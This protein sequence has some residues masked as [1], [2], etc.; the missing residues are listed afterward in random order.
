MQVDLR[1]GSA[2]G[3]NVGLVSSF[4][5]PSEHGMKL[6]TQQGPN[7][8]KRKFLELYRLAQNAAENLRSFR[9]GQLASG[10]LQLFAYELLGRSNARATNAPISAVAIVWYGLSPRMGSASLPFRIPISTWSM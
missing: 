4:V 5:E 9:I 10:N 2:E 1:I 7:Q 6:L 3:R 8:G